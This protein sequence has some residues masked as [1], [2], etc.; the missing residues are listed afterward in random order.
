MSNFPL[1]GR[2]YN[3]LFTTLAD[4]LLGGNLGKY[5]T[6]S[7]QLTYKKDCLALDVGY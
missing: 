7:V 5:A 6:R 4:I 1:K 3:P 2:A